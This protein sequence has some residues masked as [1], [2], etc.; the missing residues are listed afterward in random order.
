MADLTPGADFAP[1]LLSG[2]TM[3]NG[4]P[5][6]P[7]PS[8]LAVAQQAP[9]PV[10]T[11]TAP[12]PVVDTRTGTQKLLSGLLSGLAGGAAAPVN[13]QQGGVLGLQNQERNEQKVQQDIANQNQQQQQAFQN[14]LE[15]AQNQ[16]AQVTAN[17]ADELHQ[18]QM[19]VANLNALE[20]AHRVAFLPIDDQ[21]AFAENQ[22][23][24]ADAYKRTGRSTTLVPDSPDALNNFIKQNPAATNWETVHLH[25]PNGQGEVMFV[26]PAGPGQP[27]LSA[28][29]KFQAFKSIGAPVS[30]EEAASMSDEDFTKARQAYTLNWMT[31]QNQTHQTQLRESAENARNNARIAATA[32]KQN[33]DTA[34]RDPGAVADNVINGGQYLGDL[35]GRGDKGLKSEVQ[36]ILAK[37]GISEA[38]LMTEEKVAK[39]KNVQD[40]VTSIGTLAGVNGQPGA[41]QEYYDA[42]KQSNISDTKQLNKLYSKGNIDL[43]TP[44]GQ[45]LQKVHQLAVAAQDQYAKLIGGGQSTDSSRKQAAELFDANFGHNTAQGALDGALI[46]LNKRADALGAQSR[47]VKTQLNN[48][49]IT[50][51]QSKSPASQAAT[52]PFQYTTKDGKQGWNGTAWVSTGK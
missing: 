30:K 39:Q 5:N 14:Q 31:G 2:Q 23:K 50:S 47:Y 24:L 26:Q 41:I 20:A 19:H 12:A 49:Q 8:P 36:T 6:L 46:E 33:G 29:A 25:S 15:Q 9:D 32:Q 44:E 35:T 34:T 40:T 18:V 48:M 3:D 13:S 1:S 42:L 28:D 11:P 52:Q 43:G 22:A 16:R 51:R 37:R 21:V 17:N 10:I 45:Q 4:A 27:K 7:A 38:Q